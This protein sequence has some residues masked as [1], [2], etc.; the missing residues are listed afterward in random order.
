MPKQRELQARR[1]TCCDLRVNAFRRRRLHPSP[2][3]GPKRARAVW[4]AMP[5]ASSRRVAARLR[6]AGMPVSHQTIYR[7]QKN[8]W[9]PVEGTEHPLELARRLLNDVTP[10]LTGDPLSVAEDIVKASADQAALEKL[11]DRELL[12]RN[13]RALAAAVIAVGDAF[14]RHPT[15][16][17]S[18][19]GEVAVLVR[20]LTACVQVASA[21]FAQV[22][23]LDDATR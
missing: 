21:A 11:P 18:R 22:S 1:V 12:R 5:R 20:A 15:I 23:N 17:I 7:W 10:L 13:A 2:T 8:R 6:R 19:P 4:E 9:R 16:V 14:L 3:D